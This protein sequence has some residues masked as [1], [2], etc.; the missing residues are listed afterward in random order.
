MPRYQMS[1]EGLSDLIVY[2]KRLGKD[3][4]P[5]ISEDKIVIG[6]VVPLKGELMEL[7]QAVKAATSAYFQELNSQGGIYNRKFEVKFTET[8]D[9]PAATRANV[10][11]LI[12]EEQIFALTAAFI[13]GSEK[14]IVPLMAQQEVP[15]IVP[16]TLYPQ[17]DCPLN[18]HVFYLLSG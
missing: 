2:V 7:G 1:P 8:G 6:T 3:R 10:E 14:E 5:G 11:R 16:L 15:V 13:A 4:D 9:T 12:K 17:T 18:R